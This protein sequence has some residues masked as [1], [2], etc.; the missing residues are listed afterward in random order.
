MKK[1]VCCLVALVGLSVLFDAQI[2]STSIKG[3]CPC[4][5]R[6]HNKVLQKKAQQKKNIVYKYISPE[7]F[8]RKMDLSLV[9]INVTPADMCDK[10]IVGTEKVSIDNLLDYVIK[11]AWPKNKPIIV[12]CRR[13]IT[14]KDA[15]QLLMAAGYTNVSL[16]KGGLDRWLAEKP[17]L[18]DIRECTPQKA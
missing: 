5:K 4:R 8:K 7:R 9:V 2:F 10:H 15:Y 6:R 11:N 14:S 13:G 12:Y 18:F 1:I 17:T 3:E 16:V